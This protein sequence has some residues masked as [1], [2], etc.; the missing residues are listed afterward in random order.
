MSDVFA[1]PVFGFG[2]GT[3]LFGTMYVG[4]TYLI[5][6]MKWVASLSDRPTERY[7]DPFVRLWITFI[8]LGGTVGCA[9]AF[10]ASLV[11]AL[12]S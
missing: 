7:D 12:T 5:R 11:G 9:I 6:Y 3:F 8:S 2:L 4:R 10:F 1:S